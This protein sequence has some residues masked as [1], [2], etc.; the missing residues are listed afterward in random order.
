MRHLAP[1]GLALSALGLI[2]SVWLWLERLGEGG[3]VA[4]RPDAPWG[5]LVKVFPLYGGSIYPYV[6]SGAL[7][8]ALGGLAW[9]L[10]D[11]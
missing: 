9:R 10:R 6:L 4:G 5:P 1:L 2:A 11:I 3:L 7:A 8:L